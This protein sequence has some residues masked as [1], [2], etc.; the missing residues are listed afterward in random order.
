MAGLL[1]CCLQVPA[2]LDPAILAVVSVTV[3]FP[4]LWGGWHDGQ[5]CLWNRWVTW[6]H[7]S[8]PLAANQHTQCRDGRQSIY[9]GRGA[10]G[11]PAVSM[12]LNRGN[13]HTANR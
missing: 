3:V 7:M 5:G 11:V 2:D 4:H 8:P 13:A 6:P 9:P 10:S 1:T 12:E